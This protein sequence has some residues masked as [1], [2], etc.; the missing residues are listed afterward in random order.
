MAFMGGISIVLGGFK[1]GDNFFRLE[2]VGTN[3]YNTAENCELN[4]KIYIN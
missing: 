1:R 4:I 2:G 3:L